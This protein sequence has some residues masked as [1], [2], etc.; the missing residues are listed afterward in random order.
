MLCVG[1]TKANAH[2]KRTFAVDFEEEDVHHRIGHTLSQN[3]HYFTFTRVMAIPRYHLNPLRVVY[4][5]PKSM[6]EEEKVYLWSDGDSSASREEY[7][8][9]VTLNIWLV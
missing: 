4:F 2:K 7:H 5:S 9:K 3:G 8:L 6:R 1:N